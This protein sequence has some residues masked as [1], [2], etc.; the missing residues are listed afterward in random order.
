MFALLI[1]Q[2]K[3]EPPAEPPLFDWRD[4]KGKAEEIIQEVGRDVSVISV[5]G[6]R[7]RKGEILAASEDAHNTVVQS[8]ARLLAEAL[9]DYANAKAYC[10]AMDA[11]C[12]RIR[13][14]V[15]KKPMKYPEGYDYSAYQSAEETVRQYDE[16][17]ASFPKRKR[18]NPTKTRKGDVLELGPLVP[19]YW[20]ARDWWMKTTSGK[21]TPSFLGCDD[22]TLGSG[23]TAARNATVRRGGDHNNPDARFLLM[24]LRFVEPKCRQ[25]H[26]AQ[27]YDRLRGSPGRRAR[28]Q[29]SQSKNLAD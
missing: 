25:S 28:R 12:K 15:A 10:E 6:D 7:S 20:L 16:I 2:G 18:G 29:N 17:L 21:F 1:A 5:R 22:D 27:V 26:A 19:V 4:F 8:L 11:P 13:P 9:E 3:I 14:S 24:V 23:Q